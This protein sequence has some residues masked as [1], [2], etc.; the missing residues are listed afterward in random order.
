MKRDSRV[1][2]HSTSM[3]TN[4][5]PHTSSRPPSSVA[6]ADHIPR[7]GGKLINTADWTP[8]PAE[9]TKSYMFR[10]LTEGHTVLDAFMTS[11][12]AQVGQIMLNCPMSL[13]LMGLYSG[14]IA[15]FFFLI[16]GYWTIY[17]VSELNSMTHNLEVNFKSQLARDLRSPEICF[18]TLLK[19]V[20]LEGI[21]CC[22]SCPMA[23]V[24]LAPFFNCSV[25]ICILS[26]ILNFFNW[27]M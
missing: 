19:G 23:F 25:R 17:Q 3:I 13:Y 2:A 8:L 14:A 5:A 16:F 24:F 22:P 12:D 21:C 20:H 10:L 4:F 26:L 9:D 15:M 1:S 18:K 27:R 7:R 11:A 6:P